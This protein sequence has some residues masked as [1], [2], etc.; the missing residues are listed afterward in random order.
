M[1]LVR[2][3]ENNSLS[4]PI[5]MYHSICVDREKEIHPYFHIN[6]TSEVFEKQMHYL[7]ENKYQIINLNKALSLMNSKKINKE[8]YVVITF[9]DGYRDFFTEAYPILKK[10]EF[11]ATVFVATGHIGKLLNNKPCLSWDEIRF[12]NK[13]NIEFGSHTVNHPKLYSFD[14]NEIVFELKESKNTIEDELGSEVF[15]F[16]YPYAF[17]QQDKKFVKKFNKTLVQ[18]NYRIGVTTKIGTVSKKDNPLI[19]KRIPVNSSDDIP[20]FKA[21]LNGA[22]NWLNNFQ[23]LYKSVKN[24]KYKKSE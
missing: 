15:S 3:I 20:L 7:H 14:I 11:N 8:K 22:Y 17:P 2:I 18:C 16:S 19:L 23:N 13:N 21:K 24:T 1:P 5:L 9:D 10:Y 4:I 6:T 12:L